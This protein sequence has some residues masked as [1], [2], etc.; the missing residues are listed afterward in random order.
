VAE[1]PA[2]ENNAKLPA[3]AARAK[4]AVDLI[5]STRRLPAQFDRYLPVVNVASTERLITVGADSRKSNR[6]NAL[7]SEQLTA[8]S[9]QT[10]L[11][12]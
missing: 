10:V 6:V 9:S 12:A 3:A 8:V 5:R 7:R 1:Q 4:R 2:N 11:A